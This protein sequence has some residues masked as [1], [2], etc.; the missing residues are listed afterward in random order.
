MIPSMVVQHSTEPLSQIVF[1][2]SKKSIK[3]S[4][5]TLRRRFKE[6]SVDSMK[7]TSKPFLTSDNVFKKLQRN[8]DSKTVT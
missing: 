7:L 5:I 1:R 2:L 3:I 8:I 6:V 4:K